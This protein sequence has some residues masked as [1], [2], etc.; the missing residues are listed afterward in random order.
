MLSPERILQT[1]FGFRA[2]RVLLSAVELGLFTELGKGP[3]TSRQLSRA[4][5][6]DER[7]APDWLD[8][9]VA[10][11]FLEREGEGERAIYLNTREGAHFL[12][13]ASAG[14]LGPVLDEA[15][16]EPY[17]AWKLL[18]PALRASRSRKTHRNGA[19][20]RSASFAAA[21]VTGAG[22][23]WVDGL[24]NACAAALAE[25]FDV[26]RYS[27]VTVVGRSKRAFA[28]AIAGCYPGVKQIAM[29]AAANA[30]VRRADLL[31]RVTS[32]RSPALPRA[33]TAELRRHCR[34]LPKGGCLIVIEA[35]LND[36]A[37]RDA[38]ALLMS[39][40]GHVESRAIR[41]FSPADLQ[42]AC[43]KAGFARTETLPLVWPVGAVIAFKGDTSVG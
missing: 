31:I 40:A 4:L 13:R 15:F 25:R 8:A 30:P 1:G 10:L 12:N 36:E 32:L 7:S 34:A 2:S 18:T 38:F 24:M 16:R 9:L 14:Y 17:E 6:L 33:A 43:R 23:T 22:V 41:W 37:R 42:A 27:A 11:G 28:G 35:L 3:R 20:A 26:S 39:L 21:A 29:A 5:A 19:A